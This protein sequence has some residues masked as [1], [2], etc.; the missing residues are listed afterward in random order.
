MRFAAILF[1]LDGTLLNT[2]DDLANSLNFVLKRHGFPEHEVEKYKYFVGNGMEN[3]VRRVLP[4]AHQDEKTVASLLAEFQKRYS[5]CWHNDTRPYQGI[6]K[7]LDSL[8]ALGVKMS[9]LSNKADQ[10]T[11]IMIDYFFGL[12]RFDFVV[13]ARVGVP[14]KPDPT[15]ALEIIKGSD[16]EPSSY[17]YL[18]D[19]GVDMQTANAAGLFALGATWGFRSIKELETNGA[20]KLIYN[21]MEI[22]ELIKG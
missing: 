17:L 14:N 19:S 2:I 16:I 10:F 15:A 22:I 21:P 3:L 20:K 18:G 7:L 11:S 4:Q 9:V 8:K 12:D 1:D 13:G 6:I 5:E